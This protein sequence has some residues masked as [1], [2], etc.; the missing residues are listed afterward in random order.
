MNIDE[1]NLRDVS[2]E[3]LSRDRIGLMAEITEIVA[4]FDVQ[5]VHYDAKVLSDDHGERLF[6]CKISVCVDNNK[7]RML[8]NRLY[9]I[10]GVLKLSVSS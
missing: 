7:L 1:N 9:R 4:G 5:T 10:K 2:I 8:H 3:I 6:E